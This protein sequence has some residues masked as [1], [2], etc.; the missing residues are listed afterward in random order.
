LNVEN[1]TNKEYF[2]Y[3]HNNNNIS[4]GSPTAARVTLIYNF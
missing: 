4:P 2:L 3:A 1:I